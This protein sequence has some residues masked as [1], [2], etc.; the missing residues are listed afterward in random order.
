MAEKQRIK[1][2][3]AQRTGRNLELDTSSALT[4]TSP[5]SVTDTDT[6]VGIPSTEKYRIPKKKY[7]KNR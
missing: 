5:G 7:R 1:A 6:E 2:K 4:V 3:H